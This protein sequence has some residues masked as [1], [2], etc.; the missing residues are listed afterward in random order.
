LQQAA[1]QDVVLIAGKGHESYQDIQG[2]RRPF[3]D[4]TEAELA[5]AVYTKN[6]G[7]AHKP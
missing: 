1:P 7:N 2:V 6:A 4:R 5:L 3:S